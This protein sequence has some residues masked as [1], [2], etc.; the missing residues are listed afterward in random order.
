MSMQIRHL[1][2]QRG[3]IEV[4]REKTLANGCIWQGHADLGLMDFCKT[5]QKM[6]GCIEP[7]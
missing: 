1:M 4:I 6:L 5:T 2:N 3:Q 7:I